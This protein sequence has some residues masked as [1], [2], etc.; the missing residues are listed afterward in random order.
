AGGRTFFAPFPTAPET[1]RFAPGEGHAR[2]LSCHSSGSHAASES[3][4]AAL[5][6]PSGFGAAQMHGR[7]RRRAIPACG[8]AAVT[9]PDQKGRIIRLIAKREEFTL[10][11]G[12]YFR[13]KTL[14]SSP[15]PPYGCRTA[16]AVWTTPAGRSGTR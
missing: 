13:T 12:N 9:I 14:Q 8:G 15:H 4:R 16:L 1:C 2:T 10:L 5:Q 6:N 7:G 11:I 3:R